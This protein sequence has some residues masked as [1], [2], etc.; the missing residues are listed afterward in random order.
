MGE[1]F[2]TSP[3]VIGMTMSAMSLSTA[4]ASWKLGKLAKAFSEKSLLRFSYLLYTISLL[5]IPLAPNVW[6]LI[7]LVILSGI[8]N[9]TNIPV[10]HSLLSGLAPMEHRAAF[11]SVNGMVLRLGQTTGPILAGAL[12]GLLSITG[13]FYAGAVLSFLMIFVVSRFI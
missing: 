8:A 10:I 12:L 2:H 4:L 1:Q 13:P 7:L 3:L 9:G 6:V 5:L 11:M